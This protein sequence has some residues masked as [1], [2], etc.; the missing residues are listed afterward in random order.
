MTDDCI[1]SDALRYIRGR[2]Y[3]VTKAAA[4]IWRVRQAGFDKQMSRAELF[5]FA[6]LEENFFG[7]Y[8]DIAQS[9]VGRST[10]LIGV[11]K[12]RREARL[13]YDDLAAAIQTCR[14]RLALEECLAGAEATILQFHAELP[15]F[16][17]G[18]GEEFAG[19]E[20]EI[21][22]AFETVEAAQ[23]FDSKHF[24]GSR[25]Q[26]GCEAGRLPGQ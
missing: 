18:D 13:A 16:W 12:T 4:N 25:A 11:I 6:G 24:N 26:P 5:A 21:E 8:A 17:E 1:L 7:Y 14:T 3:I 20:R 23:F 2:G 22:I 9:I 10:P 19:L 15:F